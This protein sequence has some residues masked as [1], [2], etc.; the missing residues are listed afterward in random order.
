[1]E[2][3]NLE[4]LALRVQKETGRYQWKIS[5]ISW[6][7]EIYMKYDTIEGSNVKIFE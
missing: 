3:Y 5:N 2:I 4:S 6:I 7:T 1:M